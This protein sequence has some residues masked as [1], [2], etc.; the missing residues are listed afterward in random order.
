ME[1]Y[2]YRFFWDCGRS[3][4]LEGLFV[5]TEE[6][7]KSAIG[8]YISF[9]EVLGKHSDVYGTLEERDIQKLDV[10]TE[11]VAEVSKFLGSDWSGFNPLYYVYTEC[12]NCGDRM[13]QDEW[14]VEYREEFDQDL[15]EECFEQLQKEVEEI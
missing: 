6:Q 1:K 15:C 9:G 5:A 7:V 11:A 12:E 8:S 14:N 4:D 2:L 13:S 10:S 3:G